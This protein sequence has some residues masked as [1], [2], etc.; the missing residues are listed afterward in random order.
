[1]ACPPRA[2]SAALSPGFAENMQFQSERKRMPLL[3]AS[4]NRLLY[5]EKD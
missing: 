3:F 4:M 2:S 5:Y 1:V